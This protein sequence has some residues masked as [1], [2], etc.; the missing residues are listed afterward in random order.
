MELE[1]QRKAITI[2]NNIHRP[3]KTTAKSTMVAKNRSSW[4]G[5][6]HHRH[7]CHSLLRC[8]TYLPL[9]RRRQGEEPPSSSR[10]LG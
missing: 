1:H 5:Y 3:A 8:A 9:A 7:R 6:S 10:V 2:S 4:N